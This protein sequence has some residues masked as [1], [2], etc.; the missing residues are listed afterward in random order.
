MDKLSNI[1]KSIDYGHQL[2][3]KYIYR[4]NHTKLN[5]NFFV[6]PGKKGKYIDDESGE[7]EQRVRRSNR[8][9]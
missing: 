1:D 2:I 4:K 8:R 9:K 5:C 7:E 3:W 6:S